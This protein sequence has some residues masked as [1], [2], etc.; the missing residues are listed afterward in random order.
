MG[1][2]PPASSIF[3]KRLV[4]D[5]R[6]LGILLAA[7]VVYI[8]WLKFLGAFTGSHRLGGALGILLGL[9][10]CSG[11]AANML[12]FLLF[13]TPDIREKLASTGP[14]R[15]WLLVNLLVVFA[16]WAVIFKS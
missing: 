15:V 2:T 9:Y 3:Q 1:V 5:F 4:N 7:A 16:A 6:L 11:P 10:I 12:D 8:G 13:M 14:G